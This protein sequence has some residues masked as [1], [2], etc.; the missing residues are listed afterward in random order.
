MIFFCLYILS[1]ENVWHLCKDIQERHVQE[2]Q[3]CYVVFISNSSR[4]VPLWRQKSGRDEDKLV[5]WVIV[6]LFY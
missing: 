6:E 3:H 4:T 5:I 1:E 2:I